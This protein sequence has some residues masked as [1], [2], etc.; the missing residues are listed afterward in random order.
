M[1]VNALTEMQILGMG[2]LTDKA[3]T[4][5]EASF[6]LFVRQHGRV[7]RSCVEKNAYICIFTNISHQTDYSAVVIRITA[8][9][10]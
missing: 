4:T 8:I 10:R 2:A 5:V 7:L 3:E 1:S 9:A 6:V